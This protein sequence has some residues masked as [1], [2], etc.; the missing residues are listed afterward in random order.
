M[1]QFILVELPSFRLKTLAGQPIVLAAKHMGLFNSLYQY[2]RAGLAAADPTSPT[3]T[4][5]LCASLLFAGGE[6]GT[7]TSSAGPNLHAE[8]SLLL[9]YFTSFTSPGA[10]PI[11]DALLMSHKPCSSCLPYFASSSGKTLHS[12]TVSGNFRARFTPRSDRSYTPI[13]YLARSLDPVARGTLWLEMASLWASNTLYGG[14]GGAGL[15][16]GQMYWLLPGSGWFAVCEQ[17]T[18]TDAEVAEVVA[19]QGGALGY[20][21]GR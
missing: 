20:W 8:E 18:M 1:P 13:F 9:D 5:E 7:W 6:P 2:V 4:P 11:V 10:Y 19:R 12:G 14:S 17:E 3:T 21:I 15:V 16:R